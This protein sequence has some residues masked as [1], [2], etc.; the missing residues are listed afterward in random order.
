MS[1]HGGRR[2]PVEWAVP[3]TAS[4]IACRL[5]PSL[6][7]NKLC[8]IEPPND[9]YGVDEGK[10]THTAEGIYKITE[11]LAVN[12]TLQSIKYACLRCACL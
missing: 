9:G 8:G 11:M 12:T 6:S 7:S 2:H 5:S 10:G 4:P 3:S 1:R